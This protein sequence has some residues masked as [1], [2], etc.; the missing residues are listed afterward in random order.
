MEGETITQIHNGSYEVKNRSL[1]WWSSKTTTTAI[2]IANP[3]I[4]PIILKRQYLPLKFWWCFSVG[5]NNP[6][7]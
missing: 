6:S 1:E 5:A 3:S 7:I 4:L 2:V